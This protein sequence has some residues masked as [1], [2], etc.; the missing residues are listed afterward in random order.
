M[1]RPIK[2]TVD[3]FPHYVTSGKTMFTIEKRYGNDG[4]AFW[5]KLLEILGSSENHYIDCSSE[6]DWLYI[7]DKSGMSEEKVEEILSL[8][9]KLDAIDSE[10]WITSK[11]IWSQNFVNNLKP[12][13]DKRTDVPKKPKVK[14]FCAETCYKKSFRDGNPRKLRFKRVSVDLTPQSKVK[15]SKVSK[16]EKSKDIH[17]D[18]TTPPAITLTYDGDGQYPV[19]QDQ[20]NNWQKN[21]PTLDVYYQLKRARD[22][23]IGNPHR[24]KSIPAVQSFITNWLEREVSIR[25]STDGRNPKNP[26]PEQGEPQR[27]LGIHL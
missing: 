18:E 10:L 16:E 15:K 12:L 25:G 14:G 7:V 3:Y 23:L 20:I 17:I 2:N 4:Y 11:I 19:T 22:W 9:A 24:C 1:A 26:D 6:A 21:Y 8:L 27:K 13:Y 5:F